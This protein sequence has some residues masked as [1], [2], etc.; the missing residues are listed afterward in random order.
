MSPHFKESVLKTLFPLFLSFA[1]FFSVF[2]Q[3]QQ[4]PIPPEVKALADELKESLNIGELLQ[5]SRNDIVELERLRS[6]RHQTGAWYRFL[7]PEM[8]PQLSDDEIADFMVALHKVNLVCFSSLTSS[9]PTG[10]SYNVEINP[11]LVLPPVCLFLAQYLDNYMKIETQNQLAD[12]MNLVQRHSRELAISAQ[13]LTALPYYEMPIY[14]YNK[15]VLNTYQ[16]EIEGP[17]HEYVNSSK[18]GLHNL[19]R[20]WENTFQNVPGL[21]S[22]DIYGFYISGLFAYVAFEQSQAR[23]FLLTRY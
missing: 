9:L 16:M 13:L 3:P 18:R 8:V 14:E 22:A 1:L 5:D 2:A 10:D 19:G 12:F 4:G 21:D 20:L 17:F 11:T 23:I 7:N 6:R 15:Q